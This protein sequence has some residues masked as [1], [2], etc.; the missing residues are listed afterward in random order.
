MASVD[1]QIRRYRKNIVISGQGV[2]VLG[3]SLMKR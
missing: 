3:R 1:A 2:I